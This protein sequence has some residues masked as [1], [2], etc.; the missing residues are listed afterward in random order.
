MTDFSDTEHTLGEII[1]N[2][3]PSHPV[4]SYCNETV[5]DAIATWQARPSPFD[6][7]PDI[8]NLPKTR[9]FVISYTGETSDYWPNLEDNQLGETLIREFLFHDGICRLDALTPKFYAVNYKVVAMDGTEYLLVLPFP[10]ASDNIAGVVVIC[11]N[12]NLREDSP[13]PV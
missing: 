7:R 10:T 9:G 13:R 11:V 1:Y 5:L 8:L 2:G 12:R 6:P 4:D 3:A